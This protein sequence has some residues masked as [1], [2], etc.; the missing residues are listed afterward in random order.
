MPRRASDRSRSQS[1]P[2]RNS[3]SQYPPSRSQLIQAIQIL[4]EQINRKQQQPML[5]FS[6][7]SKSITPINVIPTPQVSISFP[8]DRVTKL[9]AG[10]NPAANRTESV[11]PTPINISNMR[12]LLANYNDEDY[13]ISGFSNGFNLDFQ[14]PESPLN[15]RNSISTAQFPE[16]VT[17][18]IA[19]E[20]EM[21]RI[22]G[23]FEKIPFHDFKA[24]PLAI[25]Q[26]KQT[27]KFRLLH[28]LSYPYNHDSVNTNIPYES[29]H[30]TY[31]TIQD[32][33]NDVRHH[34]PKAYM[35]KTDIAEAFRL[36]PLNPSQYHLTGFTWDKHYYY[37]KCLPM[38]A[39]S[40]CK[41]F[42][43]FSDALKYIL[44]S[45]FHLK[46]VTKVLD[47]FLFVAKTQEQCQT[48]LN[49]FINL[50]RFLSVPLAPHKTVHPTT[51]LTFLG[52]EIDS[53]AMQTRIPIEKIIEYRETIENFI[54]RDHCTLRDLKSLTG[55]LQF[56]TSVIISGRAFLRR[57]YNLTIAIKNPNHRIEITPEVRS[58][59]KIWLEFLENYNGKNIIQQSITH[60]QAFKFYSDAS[61]TGFGATFR[62]EWI[63]GVWPES[64]R[65]LSITVL[66]FYPIFILLQKYKKELANSL[67]F[68][69][70][71]NEAVTTIINKQ[72]SKCTKS[73]T[74]LRPFVLAL[75]QNNINFRAIH[76]PGVK[77]VL[78][79]KI[80]RQ[81]VS[82][83]L[84]LSHGMNIQPSSIPMHLMP[85]NFKLA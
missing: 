47:D 53:D 80:S 24:S 19:D 56:T 16:Q 17:Q 66:E 21:G 52:I 62:S 45:K 50:C 20:K 15:S 43:R 79:D 44:Q 33:I 9:P 67:I 71:D 46:G 30:V 75:L 51:K 2:S 5:T 25:R 63:Q 81:Q 4:T 73:M 14:G 29:S 57:L 74:I 68:F 1:S 26:K 31:A 10:S 23:P 54:E 6:H 36:I 13:I 8:S 27:N 28:N 85:C 60:S 11:L 34:S 82:V 7:P 78:C 59:L 65:H 64:W 69:Y 40:S 41:I 55:K 84:L 18:K 12:Q 58:D 37:D 3:Q 49:C 32:A 76:I 72:T 35:A 83:R 42:E 70:C 39:S 48:S 61:G 22:A 77:N 38:G